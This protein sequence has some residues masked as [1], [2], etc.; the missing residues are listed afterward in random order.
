VG[1]GDGALLVSTS[2]GSVHLVWN[3]RR[4][5]VRDPALVRGILVWGAPVPVAPAF[6]NALPVASDLA[7]IPVAGR[8]Q[9]FPP[10]PGARVGEVFVVD[11]RQH[12]VA[13]VGGLAPITAFQA[14]L[15]IGDPLTV[16]QVGQTHPTALS[17]GEY[18]SVTHTELPGAWA[19]LPSAVPR[20]VSP[21]S[22][23]AVCAVAGGE[24]MVGVPAPAGSATARP[25]AVE[26]DEVAVPGGR[27]AIVAAVSGPAD[28]VGVLHLVTDLGVRYPIP[29][30]EVLSLLGYAGVE[31]VRLASEIVALLPAGPTLYPQ[32][33]RLPISG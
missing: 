20:L 21:S 27:A 23:T 29:S 28:S 16:E 18:A 19:G 32:A 6:V 12:A 30:A 8:G 25:S 1:L 7:R 14:A 26:A 3:G 10:V 11:G 17:A 15:L 4:A 22:G 33:A 31:P 13:L 9:A 5:L 24:V 2:D